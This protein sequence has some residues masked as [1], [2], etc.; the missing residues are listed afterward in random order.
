MSAGLHEGISN[1]VR[2]EGSYM[3]YRPTKPGGIG[4]DGVPSGGVPGGTGTCREAWGRVPGRHGDAGMCPRSGEP[5]V[6]SYHA[7][8]SPTAS[9]EAVVSLHTSPT[10]VALGETTAEIGRVRRDG[11]LGRHNDV[12]FSKYSKVAGVLAS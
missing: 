12:P 8:K 7:G 4:Q 1:H 3:S 9:G 11:A 5:A 2:H 10:D 6:T